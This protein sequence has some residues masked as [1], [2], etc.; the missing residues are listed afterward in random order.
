LFIT[1]VGTDQLGLAEAVLQRLQ[2]RFRIVA[3]QDRDHAGGT[4]GH[5]HAAQ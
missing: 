1:A 5:Q 3:E 4:A 2:Q